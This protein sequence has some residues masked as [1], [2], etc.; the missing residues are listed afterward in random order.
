MSEQ[1]P[2]SSAMG[3]VHV[4]TQRTGYVTD[5]PFGDYDHDGPRDPNGRKRY[6]EG[7]IE[8]AVKW[9]DTGTDG[10][11]LAH[12]IQWIPQN[13]RH[14]TDGERACHCGPSEIEGVVTHRANYQQN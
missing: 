9:D 14:I 3:F 12:E 13:E 11:V 4:P 1:T 2:L 6:I 8:Y 7:T 5:G 10:E